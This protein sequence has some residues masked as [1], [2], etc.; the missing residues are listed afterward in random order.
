MISHL[1][2]RLYPL[3]KILKYFKLFFFHTNTVTNSLITT[4]IYTTFFNKK[5]KLLWKN[6]LVVCFYLFFFFLFTIVIIFYDAITDLACLNRIQ[7]QLGLNWP[8]IACSHGESRLRT[9]NTLI[10]GNLII[11]LEYRIKRSPGTTT[12]KI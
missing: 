12:N 1:T 2:I 11:N 6:K 7:S 9:F 8:N 10:L 5:N 4:N 3:T